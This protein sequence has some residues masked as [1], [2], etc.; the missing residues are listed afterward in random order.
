MACDNV[1]K[2][3]D[4][5]GVVDNINQVC[6][7]VDVNGIQG[8]VELSDM[9]VLF[10]DDETTSNGWFNTVWTGV[11]EF[12]FGIINSAY[13]NLYPLL[14]EGQIPPECRTTPWIVTGKQNTHI[15]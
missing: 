6:L 1:Q 9:C 3:L 8:D 14:N 13:C 12:D 5:G 7:G 15:R 4:K 11:Q 10:P 2:C